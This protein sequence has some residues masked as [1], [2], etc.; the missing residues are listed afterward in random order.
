MKDKKMK[1][2]ICGILVIIGLGIGYFLFS[3]NDNLVKLDYSELIKKIDNKEDFVLCIS[4]TTC[5]HCD[6]YKPK[7]RKIANKYDIKIYYTDVDLY[8]IND[9]EDFSSKISFDGS[10]PITLFIKNGEE[11][12]TATR[13]EGNVS[14]DKIIDKLKKN[15][16]IK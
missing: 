9:L 6:A 2:I 16:Y 13:I 1:Y 8:D 4:R 5:S 12:T 7:L 3:L 10:T 11:T 15:G 14:T